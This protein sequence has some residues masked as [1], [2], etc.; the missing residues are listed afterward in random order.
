MFGAKFGMGLI[1]RQAHGT[2]R[3]EAPSPDLLKSIVDETKN[4]EN[5]RKL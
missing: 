1:M 4:A 2:E 5:Q 3:K